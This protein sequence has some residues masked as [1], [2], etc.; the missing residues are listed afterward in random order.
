MLPD[1]IAAQLAEA[2]EPF[3]FEASPE[4]RALVREPGDTDNE[5]DETKAKAL[6][7]LDAW[8]PHLGIGA[9]REGASWR[10]NARKDGDSFALSF[11]PSGIKDFVT[12]E[13]Y[14]PI[15]IVAKIAGCEPYEAMRMLRM[16]L[17][18]NEPPLSKFIFRRSPD[19]TSWSAP[20][21][22]ERV[23]PNDP[24]M[25]AAAAI[26]RAEAGGEAWDAHSE[27]A[28]E[29]AGHNLQFSRDHGLGSSEALVAAWMMQQVRAGPRLAAWRLKM[30]RLAQP[31]EAEA[32][33]SKSEERAKRNGRGQE[34]DRA[35]G[36]QPDPLAGIQFDEGGVAAPEPMLV[37]RLLPRSGIGMLGGQS[38]VGK[39]FVMCYGATELAVGGNV[40]GY[41]VYERVGSVILA[42]EGS[43][44][45]QNRITVSRQ[46]ATDLAKLPI[47]WIGNV[48]NLSDRAEVRK[49]VARLER[50]NDR[51]LEEFNIRLGVIWID[52]LAAAA[53]FKDENDN[54]EVERVADNFRLLADLSSSFAMAT[55]HY[56]RTRRPGFA[57]RPPTGP[58]V[59]LCGAR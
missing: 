27:E 6:A 15:D 2:L 43:A 13:G 31:A 38:G 20:V 8:V 3:G 32:P 35:D 37:R 48:P 29:L 40:F 11:H 4:R 24:V 10:G 17:G 53:R 56:A 49:L 55:H 50:I 57:A 12:G 44:T 7:N 41:P 14:S 5:W 21:V 52:T 34:R 28:L 58:C 51:F 36:E 46:K 18:F 59:M 42:A 47:A 22:C 26:A 45:M 54:S 25:V 16:Q 30:G 19:D 1:D 9:R 33:Q 39:S 23:H